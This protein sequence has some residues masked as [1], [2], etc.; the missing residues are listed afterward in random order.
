MTSCCKSGLHKTLD[1]IA[2]EYTGTFTFK[3]ADEGLKISVSTFLD[4][5]LIHENV[6]LTDR[7]L[8]QDSELVSKWNRPQSHLSKAGSNAFNTTC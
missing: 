3:D 5:H 2:G 4:V 8:K 6:A 1:H 7:H